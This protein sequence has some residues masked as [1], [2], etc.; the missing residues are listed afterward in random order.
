MRIVY[1]LL[2]I[3]GFGLTSYGYWLII[4]DVQ[5]EKKAVWKSILLVIG[6][7][8]MIFG[9]LLYGVPIFFSSHS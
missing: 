9:I 6:I 4:N 8:L 1:L 3:I 7:I 5:N 2:S